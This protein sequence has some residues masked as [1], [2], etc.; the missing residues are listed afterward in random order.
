MNHQLPSK[1]RLRQTILRAF[2]TKDILD[3]FQFRKGIVRK[4]FFAGVWIEL[5]LE[6]LSP[7]LPEKAF[8][9]RVTCRHWDRSRC[10]CDFREY[11]SHVYEVGELE[12]EEDFDF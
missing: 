5:S 2:S 8:R 10:L 12:V 7:G 9:A 3:I 11:G 4:H 6:Y 1:N